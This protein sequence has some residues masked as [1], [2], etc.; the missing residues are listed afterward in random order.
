MKAIRFYW[1]KSEGGNMINFN[2]IPFSISENILLDCQYGQKYYKQKPKQGNKVW[3]QGTRKV[4]CMAH[5]EVKSFKLYPQY[6]IH[7]GEKKELSEWKLRCLKEQKIKE[8]RADLNSTDLPIAK[9]KYYI[10]LPKYDVHSNHP[11]GAEAIYAQRMHPRVS[12]KITEMVTSGITDAAEIRRSLRHFVNHTLCMELGNKPLPHDRA[13]F[14]LKHDIVNHIC[15]A[16]RNIDFS[17]FD[18]ENLRLKVE[19]WKKNSPTSSF[20]FRPCGK[21]VSEGE[22]VHEKNILYIHQEEWRKDILLKFG[23]VITMMDAT[24]KTTKYSIPLFFLCVKTNVNY[25]VVAEFIIQSEAT[26]MIFEALSIIKSWNP[27]WNPNFF[28]TD[29]S[30]AEMSAIKML[31][32]NTKLYLCD[33]HREQAWERWVKDKKHG[34]NYI[35]ASTLLDLLRDC[36]N[37]PVKVNSTTE[38]EPPD[39]IFKLSLDRLIASDIWMKHDQVQ[40]WLSTQWLSCPELWVR[41]YRD[42]SYH[43]AVNTTNGVESQNK[44]LKYSYLPRRNVSLSR[45]ATM[46]CE[47]LNPDIHHKYLFLNHKMSPTYRTY[48]NFVPSYLHHEK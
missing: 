10:S 2:D 23:N 19:H 4:G 39:H 34:L 38:K 41:A 13:F 36:A 27:G 6:A 44:L 7:S 15:T 14:P 9:M 29:Y 30:D 25:S 33:F 3:L 42:Q 5:V 35:E 18:Q 32:P 24:Y 11:V 20:Y 47:E 16:K 37:A 43:A 48:N 21:E 40:Q 26:G 12:Q 8:L 17:K 46:L 28:I 31:L 22:D 45:L 1:Q